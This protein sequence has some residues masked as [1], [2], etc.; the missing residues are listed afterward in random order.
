VSGILQPGQD[1]G[2]SQR[3]CP[4]LGTKDV[5][6]LCRTCMDE[7]R[8]RLILSVVL[9]PAMVAHQAV[10]RLEYEKASTSQRSQSAIPVP[11][12]VTNDTYQTGLSGY[13][14]RTKRMP[15]YCR[16]GKDLTIVKLR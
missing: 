14:K 8:C 4:C 2:H 16:D 11:R 6:N 3:P 7:H 13:Y 5:S 10:T 9:S 15:R 12:N 1:E